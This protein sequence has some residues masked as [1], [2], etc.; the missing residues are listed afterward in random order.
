MADL[1]AI[2]GSAEE[3]DEKLNEYRDS[4]ASQAKG[5]SYGPYTDRIRT[6]LRNVMTFVCYVKVG[7]N[8][9]VETDDVWE[10][11]AWWAAKEDP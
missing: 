7:D 8:I 1:S 4:L 11:H 6:H 2:T 9:A 5:R 10:G 3:R